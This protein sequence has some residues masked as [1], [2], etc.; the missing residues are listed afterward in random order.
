MY[1]ESTEDLSAHVLWPVRKLDYFLTDEGAARPR[2]LLGPLFISKRLPSDGF[3]FWPQM[4]YVIL[5]KK[6]SSRAFTP[7]LCTEDHLFLFPA[8]DTVVPPDYRYDFIR[9]RCL[10]STNS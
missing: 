3:L 8:I 10:A 1:C 7:G 2:R 4:L 5:Q 6:N 9:L